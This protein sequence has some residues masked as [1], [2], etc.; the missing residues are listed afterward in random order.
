MKEK[1]K[2]L[3]F[4]SLDFKLLLTASLLCAVCSFF[5]RSSSWSQPREAKKREED[6]QCS[7]VKKCEFRSRSFQ[8]LLL[9]DH[10][11]QITRCPT[12]FLYPSLYQLSPFPSVARF[13]KWNFF[14]SRRFNAHSVASLTTTPQITASSSS[15]SA[16]YSLL[17]YLLCL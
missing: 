7:E 5:L 9:L 6:G 14:L 15:S 8:M 10:C 2:R 13:T 12:Q 17:V 4:H 1:R 3:I 11:S 16:H